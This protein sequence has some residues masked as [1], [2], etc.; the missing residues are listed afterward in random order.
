[1]WRFGHRAC[2]RALGW[3]RAGE[4]GEKDI[5]FCRLLVPVGKGH[6]H[7]FLHLHSLPTR[8]SI[9]NGGSPPY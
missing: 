4:G 6:S 1:M 5:I 7:F 9:G 8:S 2:V 3:R